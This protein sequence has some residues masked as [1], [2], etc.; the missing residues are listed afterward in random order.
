MQRESLKTAKPLSKGLL[1]T[2]A[3]IVA[4]LL[5][6]GIVARMSHPASKNKSTSA[7]TIKGRMACLPHKDM[8]GPHTLECASGLK[9][10]D[11]TYYGLKEKDTSKPQIMYVNQNKNVT[12]EGTFFYL[13]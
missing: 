5:V 6:V 11:G 7:I 13:L 9:A 10:E 3:V 2:V 12:I 8:D 1:I 4:L